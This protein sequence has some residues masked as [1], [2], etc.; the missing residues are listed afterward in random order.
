MTRISQVSEGQWVLLVENAASF[1]TWTQTGYHIRCGHMRSSLP[2]KYMASVLIS[3][4]FDSFGFRG[5]T[6]PHGYSNYTYLVLCT[7]LFR[8]TQQ[9]AVFH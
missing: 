4:S 1:L 6:W 3:G 9:L 2:I 8:D 5:F 7:V